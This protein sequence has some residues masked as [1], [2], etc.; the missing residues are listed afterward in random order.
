MNGEVPPP[1]QSSLGIMRRLLGELHVQ[2]VLTKD[3]AIPDNL[4]ALD[5]TYRGLCQRDPKSPMR[6]IGASCR[7]T[8]VY[9][10]LIPKQTSSPSLIGVVVQH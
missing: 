2:G 1:T 4:D 8:R 5:A 7:T 6:R 9:P 10:N 3:L